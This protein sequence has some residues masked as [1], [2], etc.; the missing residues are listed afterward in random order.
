MGMK[1]GPEHII[2]GKYKLLASVGNGTMGEVYKAEHLTI[3]KAVAVK[4]LHQN[5]TTNPEVIERFKREA[6]AAAAIED[7]HVCAVMDF[8]VTEEGDFYLVM[9]YLEGETLLQRIRNEGKLSP[10]SAVGIMQQLLSVLQCAHDHG[11]VHRDVKPE[12]I[13]LINRDNIPDFVK[14]LDFGIAH[15][16]ESFCVQSNDSNLKTQLGYLYGT[17][18]YLSPEQATGSEIDY[19]ADL[20]SCGIVLYEMLT[21]TVPFQNPSTLK[22]LHMQAYDPPPH[23]PVDEI[24][25]GQQFDEIIQKLLE[26]EPE[27]RF[28]SAQ[29]LREALS[30]LP[31]SVDGLNTWGS[32]SLSLKAANLSDTSLA[33]VG[34]SSS[35][36]LSDPEMVVR[37]WLFG[38]T[39]KHFIILMIA[40]ALVL[41]MTGVVITLYFVNQ[42]SEPE[43][44]G[45]ANLEASSEQYAA[46]KPQPLEFLNSD[47]A[48]SYD[49][50]L[51]SESTM[52]KALEEF[53]ADRFD[54]CL[55]TLD[56]VYGHYKGHPNYLRLRLLVLDKQKNREEAVKA[57]IEL[58]QIEPRAPLNLSV[59][60]ALYNIVEDKV[61]HKASMETLKAAATPSLALSLSEAILQ[62]PYDRHDIRRDRLAAIYEAMPVD[63]LPK[64]RRLAVEAW[65]K[66]DKDKCEKRQELILEAYQAQDMSEKALSEFYTSLILPLHDNALK[67]CKKRNK[68]FDCNA[69]M[70][71]WIEEQYEVLTNRLAGLPDPLLKNIEKIPETKRNQDGDG[72]KPEGDAEKAETT[73]DAAQNKE[74][75]AS[76]GN[77]KTSSL[78]SSKSFESAFKKRLNEAFSG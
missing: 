2:N 21:G 67:L 12:N 59:R 39:R 24:E 26:K 77:G 76:S 36:N 73:G 28:S 49:P 56:S 35:E 37:R 61:N 42:S 40:V 60:T 53:N 31:L 71:D 58:C 32:I 20:Y 69:C 38:L 44:I 34:A 50:V 7:S 27:N 4:I 33:A 47:F 45:Q 6:Q 41:L 13:I 17:P 29:A 1:Y 55:K 3:H 52:T 22:V 75:G 46:R 65:T 5:M 66:V 15:Q 18:Q 72:A 68:S 16:D 78:S 48:F 74:T 64:W 43:V 14:L 8:D 63:A 70:R 25:C 57:Y 30:Q 11:I 62:T 10:H 51:L 23:L 54:E 19:R 9:E